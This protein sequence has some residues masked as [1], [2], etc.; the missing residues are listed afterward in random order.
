MRTRNLILRFITLFLLLYSLTVFSRGI[1]QL[2]RAES[3]V[4]GYRAELEKLRVEN[5]VLSAELS[6]PSPEK[7]EMLARTKLGMV[8]PYEKIYIFDSDREEPSWG[9]K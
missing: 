1:W 3:T 8:M 2:S 7:M 6:E 4:E 9:Q 5:A